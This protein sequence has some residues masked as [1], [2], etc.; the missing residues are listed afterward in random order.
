[1]RWPKFLTLLWLCAATAYAGAA[2]VSGLYEGRVPVADDSEAARAE[3]LQAA[4]AQVLVKLVGRRDESTSAAAEALRARAQALAQSYQYV[5]GS[6]AP[7]ELVVGF[8]P[9]GVDAAMDESGLLRWGSQRPATLL[10]VAVEGEGG[11][12][13]LDTEDPSA[14]A[15]AITE[16]ARARGVPVLFPL[17]D[18]EEQALVGPEALRASEREPLLALAS[19]YATE[20]V[21][22]VYAR[23]AEAGWTADWSLYRGEDARQWQ[24]SG[25]TLQE[26]LG[27]GVDSLAD[28]LA[29]SAEGQRL[30]AALPEGRLM[31]R[32]RGVVGF[33]DYARVDHYLKSLEGLEQ[34]RLTAAASGELLYEVVARGGPS[35]VAQAVQA[36]NLLRPAPDGSQDTYDLLPAL[37]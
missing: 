21:A 24:S 25:A 28:S 3:A 23:P 33:T 27:G 37:Q 12:A 26:A 6:G 2:E 4:L 32:I 17:L 7:L 36:G 18:L 13:L 30:V 9:A 8:D 35:G 29:E 16:R 31:V 10:W 22:G 15:A 5:G 11:A 20:A 19:R 14:G 1:M 34:A